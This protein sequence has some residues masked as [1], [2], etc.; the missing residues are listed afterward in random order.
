[1][2]KDTFW[3][4]LQKTSF[5]ITESDNF[6]LSGFY[7]GK[8]TNEET[9]KGSLELKIDVDQIKLHSPVLEIVSGTVIKSNFFK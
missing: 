5:I 4:A 6:P 8:S 7:E 2:Q 9:G 3:C 1:M